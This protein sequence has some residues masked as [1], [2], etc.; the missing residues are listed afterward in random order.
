M[1]DRPLYREHQNLETSREPKENKARKRIEISDV[2]S[3][4]PVDEEEKKGVE[5]LKREIQTSFESLGR[6]PLNGG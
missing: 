2:A 3:S 1:V 4:M 6:T 5:E